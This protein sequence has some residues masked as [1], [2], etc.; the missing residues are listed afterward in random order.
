SSI[1]LTPERDGVFVEGKESPY[2]N[3]IVARE[4]NVDAENVQNFVKAY[5]T[6]EVYTAAS[7]I[8]QGGAVKGW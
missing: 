6:E 2:V 5:Q 7:E 4:D 8:F 1:N 3:L